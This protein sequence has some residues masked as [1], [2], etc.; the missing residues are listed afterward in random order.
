MMSMDLSPS[1]RK[2][3]RVLQQSRKPLSAYA[4]LA[5]LQRSGL[6]FP[7]TVY[8]ALDQLARRGLAHR[9]ESM[10]AFIACRNPGTCPGHETGVSAFALCTVCGKV[11]EISGGPLLKIVREKGMPFFTRLDRT[12]VELSGICR[13]CGRA[14]TRN[15]EK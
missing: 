15:R 8:R 3:L 2:V 14:K 13:A 9:L 12:V 11:Q 4:I 1:T 6:R 5:K 7:P 10:N